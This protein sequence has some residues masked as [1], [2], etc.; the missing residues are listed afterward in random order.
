MIEALDYIGF[1]SPNAAE[2]ETF[3]PEVLGVQLAAPGPGGAVRMRVD[4]AAHRLTIHPGDADDLAYLGW[5]VRGPAALADAAARLEAEG[6][7]VRR[8]DAGL[9]AER[10][11]TELAWFTDLFGFRHELAWGQLTEPAGFRP[12]RPLSGFLTGGQG[13]GHAVLIV[14]DLDAAEAFYGRVMGFRVSDQIDM[15]GVPVRFYHCNGRHH[16][17]ALVHV[18]GVVGYHHL[19]LETTALDDVGTAYDVVL[20]RGIP[21]AMTLGRHTN[22]LMTSFY[23]R[24]PSGFEIEYGYG[25]V[26]IADTPPSPRAFAKTSIWGH[27]FPGEPLLP[28]IAKPFPQEEQ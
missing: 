9:A 2:W 14:P 3:G 10:G 8:G 28:G 4:D 11:V 18:P 25:G 17:L 12:G 27:H 15:H 26:P 16:S 22:D 20:E 21:L 7:D 5:G 6:L 1:R 24:T 23:V 13:L 19:M